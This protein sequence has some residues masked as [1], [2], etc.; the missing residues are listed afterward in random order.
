MKGSIRTETLL[1]K[2]S[3]GQTDASYGTIMLL[4]LF[5]AILF[6]FLG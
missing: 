5:L 4:N 1:E 2:V 6:I 3:A